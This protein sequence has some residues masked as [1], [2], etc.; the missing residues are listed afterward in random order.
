M[1]DSS[2]LFYNIYDFL[3]SSNV[4]T[5]TFHAPNPTIL[6]Y[7][8]NKSCLPLPIFGVQDFAVSYSLY[9]FPIG[10]KRGSLLAPF[11][12][13]ISRHTRILAISLHT[14]CCHSR[15]IRRAQR[16]GSVKRSRRSLKEEEEE[17]GEHEEGEEAERRRRSGRG[18]DSA[19]ASHPIILIMAASQLQGSN[20]GPTRVP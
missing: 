3:K 13:A 1:I 12:P 2:T 6:P 19:S 8:Q 4:H 10:P 14:K 16:G 15:R 11:R 5:N 18:A 7:N 17:E 9:I 20:W